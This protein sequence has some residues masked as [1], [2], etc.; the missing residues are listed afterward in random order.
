V[1]RSDVFCRELSV[2]LI[3]GLIEE[4]GSASSLV[5]K[6]ILEEES[7]EEPTTSIADLILSAIAIDTKGLKKK[8]ATKTDMKTA[9]GMFKY[10]SLKENGGKLKKEMK[11]LAKD[12][13]NSRDDVSGLNVTELLV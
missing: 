1:T 9:K 5:G 4:V 13:A 2:D 8:K 6:L 7:R 12:I 3:I 11:K 10:S